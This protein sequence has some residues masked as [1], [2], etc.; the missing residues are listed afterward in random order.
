MHISTTNDDR[1]KLWFLKCIAMD[2]ASLSSTRIYL[3]WSKK[4]LSVSVIKVSMQ[5]VKVP[6]PQGPHNKIVTVTVANPDATSW[7]R[8]MEYAVLG[9]SRVIFYIR[10]IWL[11]DLNNKRLSHQ[12]IT[13]NNARSCPCCFLSFTMLTHYM[14]MEQQEHT[15][16]DI[17]TA[18]DG[19]TM[20]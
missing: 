8:C 9:I 17:P 6:V 2:K 20:L 11:P 3:R 18:S 15:S 19:R 4:L 7:T 13:R 12:K 10:S 5:K 1:R 16:V 14:L